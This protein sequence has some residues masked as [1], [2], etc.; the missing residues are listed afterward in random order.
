MARIAYLTTIDFGPGEIATLPAAVA[1]FGIGRPLGL[2][3]RLHVISHSPLPPIRGCP[4]RSPNDA[5][6]TLRDD[7]RGQPHHTQALTLVRIA[8]KRQY[9]GRERRVKRQFGRAFATRA[10]KPARMMIKYWANRS[11]CARASCSR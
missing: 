3:R 5:T 7:P 9:R 8:R 11:I 4:R 6:D 10:P 1:E 2:P